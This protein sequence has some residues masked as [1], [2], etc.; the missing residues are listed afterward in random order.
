MKRIFLFGFLFLCWT[1]AYSIS[2]ECICSKSDDL[3]IKQVVDADMIFRGKIISKRTEKAL[4]FGYQIVATF[5][6]AEQIRGEYKERSVEVIIGYRGFCDPDF[7]PNTEY[8]VLTK[9]NFESEKYETSV[10]IGSRIWDQTSTWNKAF[11][12]EKR[13]IDEF[14]N[15]K[16]PMIWRDHMHQIIAKGRV[17]AG[18]PIGLW[19]F[20][21]SIQT[22]ESGNFLNG[23]KEGDWLVYSR[24]SWVCDLKGLPLNCSLDD[25]EPPH[26]EGWIFSRTPYNKGVIHGTI[27]LYHESG[28]ID[29]ESYFENGVQVGSAI[30]Y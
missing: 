10:C 13:L 14:Q 5:Q 27:I 30:Q 3:S 16:Y 4:E 12:R 15:E 24:R 8:F 7:F 1:Y 6:I 2:T 20:Y 25:F 29:Q 19:E 18:R 21:N 26:P 9:Y 11:I 22:T 23:K 28:C 17:I